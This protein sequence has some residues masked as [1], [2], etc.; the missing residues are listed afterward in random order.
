[1]IRVA[2]IPTIEPEK[3]EPLRPTKSGRPDHR[4]SSIGNIFVH[5]ILKVKT[6]S[7]AEYDFLRIHDGY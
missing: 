2:W 3:F 1:M 4:T 5:S 6:M 7:E